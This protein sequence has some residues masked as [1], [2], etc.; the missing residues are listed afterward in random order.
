MESFE[1]YKTI[2]HPLVNPFSEIIG[3]DQYVIF[4]VRISPH[5]VVSKVIG[6][7]MKKLRDPGNDIAVLIGPDKASEKTKKCAEI[8][9]NKF[10]GL[11]QCNATGYKI[12]EDIWVPWDLNTNLDTL[13]VRRH[14]PVLFILL[15]KNELPQ[16]LRSHPQRMQ[17]KPGKPLASS[18]SN[19]KKGRT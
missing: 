4:D 6:Y 15:A 19:K 17:V 13:S 14:V 5:S 9:Q 2:N 10:R 3:N 8:L 18:F 16:K 7:A 12:H 1:K 11:H